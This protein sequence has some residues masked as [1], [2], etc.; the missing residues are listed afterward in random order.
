M[1]LWLFLDTNLTNLIEINKLEFIST[2]HFFTIFNKE[3]YWQN[4]EED[5][6]F[7]NFLVIRIFSIS[8]GYSKA[9]TTSAEWKTYT[10]IN[11]KFTVDYPTDWN[12]DPREN[13]FETKDVIFS[14]FDEGNSVNLGIVTTDT[15]T[16]LILK[17]MEKTL[18][19]NGV[20]L[21]II[22]D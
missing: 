20:P 1:H 17:N 10:D 5:R 4:S 21:E 19:L 8:N 15:P 11:G 2:K 6:L 7:V 13:R 3:N 12:I 22:L 9:S 18:S 14:L 16:N